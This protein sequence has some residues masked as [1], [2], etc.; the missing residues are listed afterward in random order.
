MQEVLDIEAPEPLTREPDAGARGGFIHETL[1]HYYRAVQTADRTPVTTTES[2]ETHQTQLLT[3]ALTR[4]ESAFGS[5]ADTAFHDHWLTSVLAGLGTPADNPY[6]GGESTDPDAEPSARGLLYRFLEHEFDEVATT[7]AQPTWFE[8]RIGTPHEAG[9][10]IGDG[11]ATIETPA[12]A[13]PVHGLIDRI[14]TVPETTPTQAVVRDYKTGATP[15]ETDVLLGVNFQLPVYALLAEDA[16]STIETVGA[17]YYQVSPPT[18]VNSKRG[19][20][21]S[22]EMVTYYGADTVATPLVRRLYPYFDTHEAFRSFVDQTTPRRIGALATA[23]REGAFQPTVL[24]P[25]DAGCRFCEYA[26]VCDVRPHQRRETIEAIERDDTAGYVPPL[27]H[28]V[29]PEDVVEVE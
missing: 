2:F 21:T 28:D 22:D 16:L 1:E 19:Q 10:P 24:D 25:A 17:S 20:F 3:V 23:V 4:L 8:A 5:Y 7:T 11:P 26:H 12:G 14:D 6:Y 29:A 13:I 18:S 15:T 27:A 9:T